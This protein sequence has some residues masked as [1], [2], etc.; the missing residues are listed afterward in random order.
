MDPAGRCSCRAHAKSWINFLQDLYPIRIVLLTLAHLVSSIIA[1]YAKINHRYHLSLVGASGDGKTTLVRCVMNLFG[2]AHWNLD[3]FVSAAS[4][5]NRIEAEG[6]EFRHVPYN[7]DDVKS[8]NI[9]AAGQFRRIL[10]NA[11][12][13][14][15][16]GD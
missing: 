15:S 6:H 13:G 10:Q 3:A 8:S 12:D 9:T 16:R 4:T 1:P 2:S 14:T 5:P 7:I 11:A